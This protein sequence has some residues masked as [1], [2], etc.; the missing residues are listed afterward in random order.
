MSSTLGGFDDVNIDPREPL[1]F[2]GQSFGLPLVVQRGDVPLLPPVLAAGEVDA[3]Q[4]GLSAIDAA[5]AP[6]LS[7][8][9]GG[10]TITGRLR[11]VPRSG[12]RGVLVDLAGLASAAG[13]PTSQ[14]SYAVWLA[15][16]DSDREQS[17]R[18]A[19]A[20]RGIVVTSRDS[21]SA[22][23]QTLSQEGPTLALRLALLAGIVALVLAASVLVVGIATSGASRA[24]DLAGLRI[25][26]VPA[27]TIRA[28]AIYEHVT[29]AVLGVVAGVAFGLVAAQ[30]AL[31]QVPLFAQA[32]PGLPIVRDP[33]WDAVVLAGASCLVLLVLISVLV[34]Q[35]LAK[36]ATPARLREGR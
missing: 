13:P 19:L 21:I 16:D 32:G 9:S 26:G 23:V 17:V 10:Y 6:D 25:V 7:G 34:G 15:A 28:A 14:T 3:P 2:E 22:H 18:S 27:R 30:I 35:S 4:I 8:V 24:R 12:P 33:A 36:S 1:R 11:Q 5:V 20:E 31:P 29:V